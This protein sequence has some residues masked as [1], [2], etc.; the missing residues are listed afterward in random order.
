MLKVNDTLE[1]FWKLKTKIIA[2][3]NSESGK[4]G[5]VARGSFD[6]VS[7]DGEQVALTYEADH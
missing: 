2:I 1:L 7:S 6:F 5:E 4:G 3:K